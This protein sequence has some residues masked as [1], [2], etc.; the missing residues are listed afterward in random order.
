MVQEQLLVRPKSPLEALPAE[1]IQEIF[2]R[3]VE[4]NLPRASIH[5]ARALSNKVIYTWLIRLAFTGLKGGDTGSFLKARHFLPP[6]DVVA[7]LREAER[8]GLRTQILDCRWCSLSLIR[9]CQMQ[10]LRHVLRYKCQD[11]EFPT[12]TLGRIAGIELRFDNLNVYD[13]AAEGYPNNGDIVLRASRPQYNVGDPICDQRIAVWFNIGIV[14]IQKIRN[15]QAEETITFE[16]PWCQG[17]YLPDKLLCS[18]WTEAKLEFL[19][20]LSTKAFLDRDD[21]CPRATRAL[22]QVIRER[23]FATFVRL[24]DLYVRIKC[25]SFPVRWPSSNAVFRAALRHADVQDD[26][27]VRLLV[28]ERWDYIKPDDFWLKGKLLSKMGLTWCYCEHRRIHLGS[29][30]LWKNNY[31]LDCL[32]LELC[33]SPH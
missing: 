6:H 32:G 2:L 13:T 21:T 16:L 33:C 17:S 8:T 20:L 1:I 4:I 18:P 7:R 22:R 23:D 12:E 27:F 25:Y 30:R 19:Q 29:R 9:K 10:F 14:Q 3:C 31:H 26:P 15:H 24:L 28:E 5:I 11:L